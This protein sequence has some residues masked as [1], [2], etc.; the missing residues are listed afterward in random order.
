VW[1]ALYEA[2]GVMP[3]I[4]ETTPYPIQLEPPDMER[5]A[6]ALQSDVA[7]QARMRQ[8]ARDRTPGARLEFPA[9]PILTRE[10]YAGRSWEPSKM[11]VEPNYVIFRRMYFQQNN[12]ERYG[13]DLGPVTSLVSATTFLTDFL[14]WPYQ[15]A[16]DPCRFFESNAG[17]CLPGDPVPLMLYPPE[18]SFTGSLAEAAAVLT[19]V[20]L[21]P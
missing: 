18:I 15:A 6:L 3:G 21:F 13:W 11:M 14:T 12:F 8:E 20:T 2:D 5:V 19:L 9:S 1:R 7:L 17:W 10:T 4:S 16:T